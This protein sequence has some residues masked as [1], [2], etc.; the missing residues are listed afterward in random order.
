MDLYSKILKNTTTYSIDENLLKLYYLSDSEYSIIKNN[1]LLYGFDKPFY[2]WN[3]T[4]LSNYIEFYI[5][6]DLQIPIKTV[7]L[8]FSK[9]EE[10]ILWICNTELVRNNLPQ[11]LKRYL[12]GKQ[13]L[14]N[15]SLNNKDNLNSESLLKKKIAGKCKIAEKLANEHNLTVIS[16]NNYGEYS[17][18][19]DTIYEK[20]KKIALKILSGEPYLSFKTVSY[21]SQLPKSSIKNLDKLFFDSNTKRVS[22]ED[23][24]SELSWRKINTQNKQKTVELPI[25]Q[26]P[27]FDPDSEIA[28][29]SLTIPSW[30]NSINRTQVRTN[31]QDTT[32][33]AKINLKEQL[34]ILQLSVENMLKKISEVN[35]G[36]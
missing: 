36:E 21:L 1:I 31:F 22:I 26:L 5:C 9:I 30:V 25:K 27:K 2:I 24:N 20:N 4:L 18:E 8:D 34:S 29:L 14:S 3:N 23:I 16:I 13:Y 32:S 7:E 15:L 12:I 17:E 6:N 11:A 28:S 33:N 19:I 10:V 35:Y